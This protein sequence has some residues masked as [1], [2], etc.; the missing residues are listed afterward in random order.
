MQFLM[1]DDQRRVWLLLARRR[2]LV[3]RW[4]FDALYAYR[5]VYLLLNLFFL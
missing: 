4:A 5:W 3:R 2:W 1:E